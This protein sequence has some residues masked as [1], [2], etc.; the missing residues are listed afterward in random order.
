MLKAVPEEIA[1]TS[2]LTAITTFGTIGST[3]ADDLNDYIDES[4]GGPTLF[5]QTTNLKS[6][7]Q[8][9]YAV[10][11]TGSWYVGETNILQNYIIE[12][13]T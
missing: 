3:K 6:D 12:V 4:R 9:Q 11:C 1:D 7:V 10:L 2:K 5:R 8:K 13:H